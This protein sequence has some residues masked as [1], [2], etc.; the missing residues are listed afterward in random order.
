MSTSRCRSTL[1]RAVKAT[2]SACLG[3]LQAIEIIL[4]IGDDFPQSIDGRG[5]D[6]IVAGHQPFVGVLITENIHEFPGDGEADFLKPLID[7]DMP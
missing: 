2:S 1:R 3:R 4:V 7:S 6:E 5:V